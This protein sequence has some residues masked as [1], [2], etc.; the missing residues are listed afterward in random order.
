M[1]RGA[2]FIISAPSGGGKTSLAQALIDSMPQVV[3][4]VSHTTRAPRPGEE[5]G[6][7][8]YFVSPE[9][10]ARMVAAGE[11][12]EHA[13]VFGNSYGT[14]RRAVEALL[15]QGTDV[16]LTIDWQGA[17]RVRQLMPEAR[18]IFLLPPSR[19]ALESRL[20]ARGQDTDETIARRLHEAVAEMRHCREFD[21][22][23]VNDDFEA[24]LADLKAIVRGQPEHV[25]PLPPDLLER[26]LA[27]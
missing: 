18:G 26:L 4:S 16:L 27:E 22:A 17:R 6:R 24:A 12:L 7:D 1:P 9:E 14:S 25:R 13:T 21:Y 8:Y 20:R 23:V 19:D 11:F 2:L 10:F 3:R 15:D 5:H